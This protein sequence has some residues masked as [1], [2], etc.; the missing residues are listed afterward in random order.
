MGGD[1]LDWFHAIEV[2]VGF[3]GSADERVIRESFIAVLR[4]HCDEDVGDDLDLGAVS[5]C[6][7]NEDISGVEGDL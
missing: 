5:R 4:E 7:L 3:E 1:D 6:H 2:L